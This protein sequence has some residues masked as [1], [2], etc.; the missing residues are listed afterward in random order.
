MELQ[1]KVAVVV[2]G[3]AGVGRAYVLALAQAGATVVAAARSMGALDGEPPARRTL[4][5]VLQAS[6]GLPGTVR[7]QVCD[8]ES[9]AD[10]ARLIE[11]TVANFGRIDLLVNNAADLSYFKTFAITPDQ[12]DRMMRI[13]VHAPYL[14][15]RHVAPHMIRQGSGSIVNITS[16]SAAPTKAGAVGHEGLGLYAIS[17]A[18]LNRLTTFMSEELRAHGIAVNAIS[19]GWV[20]SNAHTAAEAR[21]PRKPATAEVLGPPILFL[22]RQTAETMTG[23]ILHTDEF[24]KSWP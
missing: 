10:I 3:S 7:A 9:E 8:V 17:K 15:I 2:G 21:P 5:E 24:G 22:A 4:A 1:G 6:Q 11:E 20:D 18:A 23:Q 12:W 19:P 14:T 13:N 16:G